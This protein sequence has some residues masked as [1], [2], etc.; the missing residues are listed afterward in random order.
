MGESR[1]RAFVNDTQVQILNNHAVWYVDL[2]GNGSFINFP[3]CE[4]WGYLGLRPV[5]QLLG[6]I[7]YEIHEILTIFNELCYILLHICHNP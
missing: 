3:W 1:I 5:S 7:I 2:V 4:S 6:H